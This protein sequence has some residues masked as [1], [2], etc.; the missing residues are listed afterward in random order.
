MNPQWG[1]ASG[2]HF[3]FVMGLS[4]VHDNTVSLIEPFNKLTIFYEREINEKP[5]K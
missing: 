3:H 5:D 4:E 1:A 2:R